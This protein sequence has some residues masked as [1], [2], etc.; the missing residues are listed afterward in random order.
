MNPDDLIHSIA[1][2]DRRQ[3]D[4][5]PVDP[6]S[7]PESFSIGS[8]TFVRDGVKR[9]SGL[10]AAQLYQDYYSG[11]PFCIRLTHRWDYGEHSWGIRENWARSPAEA[12][13][14][15][16]NDTKHHRDMLLSGLR[17]CEASLVELE[18][19]VAAMESL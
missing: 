19:V 3:A 4:L 17:T 14:K 10:P 7:D 6:N 8:L 15:E 5:G 1:R 12:I 13:L 18:A 11:K 16:H 2:F 9:Q